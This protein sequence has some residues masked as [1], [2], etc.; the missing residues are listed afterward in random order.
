MTAQKQSG[1]GRRDDDP[2]IRA[3]R[4]S[5]TGAIVVAVI[6]ALATSTAAGFTAY[7]SGKKDGA[8]AATATVTVTVAAPGGAAPVPE[9]KP[10]DREL[11]EREIVEGSGFGEA[12]AKVA[13]ASHPSALVGNLYA[14]GTA[15]PTAAWNTGG[16]KQLYLRAGLIDDSPS[17]RP[18]RLS[19]LVDGQR[20]GEPE[21]LQVGTIREITRP[22]AGFRVAIEARAD[23][24]G[25]ADTEVKVALLEVVLR[26]DQS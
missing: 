24:E 1:R 8:Q 15:T 25:C 17:Q 9:A 11:S 6:T 18:V 5:R 21:V 14:C 26:G 10:G 7:F 19:V 2:A 22:I 3:A 4:I 13:N 12:A 16:K 23:W 20:V